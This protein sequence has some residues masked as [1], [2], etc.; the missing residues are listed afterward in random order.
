MDLKFIFYKCSFLIHNNIL[1]FCAVYSLVFK[2]I[3]I[4]KFLLGL[5]IIKCL[6]VRKILKNV[7]EC[8]QQVFLTA[9]LK[10][11]ENA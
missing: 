1:T 8:S 4:F 7:I 2:I 11:N 6:F 9:I 5:Y 10:D 3:N